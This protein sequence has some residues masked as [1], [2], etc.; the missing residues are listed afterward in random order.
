M[1]EEDWNAE[2]GDQTLLPSLEKVLV[3]GGVGGGEGRSAT[4]MDYVCFFPFPLSYPC[5]CRLSAC[6]AVVSPVP[7]IFLKSSRQP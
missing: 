6:W 1:I 3:A 5:L 2:I 4:A 7:V